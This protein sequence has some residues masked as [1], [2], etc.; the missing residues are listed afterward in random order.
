M[1]VFDFYQFNIADLVKRKDTISFL[2][3]M[4]AGFNLG[5]KNLSFTISDLKG[6]E[7]SD[8][9]EDYPNLIKYRY[10]YE[11]YKKQILTS[12]TPEWNQGK[13]Y[14]D[15]VDWDAIIE[16]FFPQKRDCNLT[17]GIVFQQIDW[18]GVGLGQTVLDRYSEVG[19]AT[20]YSCKG[21]VNN[22]IIVERNVG[23][24]KRHNYIQVVIEATTEDA[25]RDTSDIVA[26]LEPYLGTPYS[27]HRNYYF[28]SEQTKQFVFYEDEAIMVLNEDMANFA[29]LYGD[30]HKYF[31]PNESTASIIDKKMIGEA[32]QTSDFCMNDTRQKGDRSG[33]N[34]LTCMDKHNY[35]YDVVIDRSSD[36]PKI[37]FFSFSVKGCN[38]FVSSDPKAIEANT[39]EEAREKL[40]KVARFANSLKKKYSIYLSERFD[41]TPYWF[42]QERNNE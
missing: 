5:Y 19:K 4:L 9:I 40:A 15:Q 8:L 27:Y 10:Y 13:I 18:Y 34:R 31:S 24:N 28:T 32:F 26:K 30:R 12:M 29:M 35:I 16:I 22:S 42:Y 41:D 39:K 21:I 2:G 1:R 20:L 11:R 33:M 37:F 14:A 25:P 23:E 38:F 7:I 6:K 36:S 3:K 17:G